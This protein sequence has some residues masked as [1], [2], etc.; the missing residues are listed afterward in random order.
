MTVQKFVN[1]RPRDPIIARD[2]RP[3]G[4]D[5][6]RRM[7]CLDWPLP[8]VAA[9]SLR[10]L[11]GRTLG[12]NFDS[13]MIESLKKVVCRGP[14]PICDNAL[15][16][17][18]P[19]DAV[20]DRDGNAQQLR[21]YFPGEDDGGTDLPAGLVPVL[22]SQPLGKFQ[23]PPTWWS[24]KRMSEWL[25]NDVDLT[26]FFKDESSF[27]QSPEH[28]ERSH[29]KIDP[30]TLASE[31][32]K[33]FTTNGLVLDRFARSGSQNTVTDV[34]L[35][36][37]AT[38]G[39]DSPVTPAWNGL[40]ALQ[41]LGGE[42]RLME[43]VE[44]Q[45]QLNYWKCPREVHEKLQPVK[46]GSKLRMVLASPAV[47]SGGWRPGW[48]SNS[49]ERKS[50]PPELAPGS[51]KLELVAVANQ[52]WEPVSGWSYEPLKTT[53]KPGPKAIRRMVPAG[54]V[55][56]FKVLECAPDIPWDQLWLASVSDQEQDRNDGFG[57]AMWGLW[58]EQ[59]GPL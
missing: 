50:T 10:T 57:L 13:A 30:Q 7:R 43:F 15:Y 2:G 28:D 27:L 9:G 14:L 46:A 36:L 45:T 21:P 8:S 31:E 12:G 41:P 16:V 44:D 24:M 4:L 17:P 22:G 42:R 58:D 51:L 40:S 19:N 35:A 37:M 53:K 20:L 56:F 11:L 25:V 52:R 26:K 29:L 39:V 23:S 55:Y 34:E 49:S 47:F 59:K 38:H 33:L 3:F 1:L 54:G 48:L 18:C 6:G 32:G 5:S